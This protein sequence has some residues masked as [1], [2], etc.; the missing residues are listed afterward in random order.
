MLIKRVAAAPKSLLDPNAA[1]WASVP[2]EAVALAGTTAEAQPNRYLRN[3][4]KDRPIGAVKEVRVRAAHDGDML[5]FRLEWQ[6]A[7]ENRA[8]QDAAFPDGAALLFPANFADDAST[9][10][11]TMGSPEKPVFAVYWRPD[12]EEAPQSLLA[13]GLG[14][15]QPAPGHDFATRSARDGD[16]WRVVFARPIA[17]HGAYLGA[18]TRIAVAVWEGGSG[19]R[20]G[21]KAYSQAWRDLKVEA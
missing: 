1:D 18:S 2:E 12:I 7:S 16:V 11:E 21:I 13:H 15:V 4:L 20:G 14:T 19:E 10:L 3:A 9:P 5:C 17:D 6:D 8:H